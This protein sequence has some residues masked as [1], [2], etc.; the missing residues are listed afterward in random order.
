MAR[1]HKS[2]NGNNGGLG[3]GWG[4]AL[5]MVRSSYTR[6]CCG[7]QVLDGAWKSLEVFV[8]CPAKGRPAGAFPW[9]DALILAFSFYLQGVQEG[10]P[11]W[12]GESVAITPQLLLG[13]RCLSSLGHFYCPRRTL[14]LPP[15]YP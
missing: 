12:K 6:H 13:P 10:K 1:S 3:G 4:V 9:R 11:E 7:S 14:C 15:I 5:E 8:L 2:Y